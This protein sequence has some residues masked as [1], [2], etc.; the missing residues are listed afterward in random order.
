MLAILLITIVVYLPG[1]HGPFLLDDI[2][3][4]EPI[5]RWMAGDLGWMSAVLDNRSG[6]TGRPI[7]ML[8]F[9]LDVRRTGSLDPFTFKPTNLAIHLVCGLAA[10]VL[11]RQVLQAAQWPESALRWV[12][13]AVMA[14][15][16]WM[17]VQLSTVL[18]I[19]QRMAQLS[20]LWMLAT[21]VI[22]LEARRR[23]AIRVSIGR[24]ALL[25]LAVPMAALLAVFSKENGAL[26][27]PLAA[28]AEY[29]LF[30]QTNRPRAVLPF[31]AATVLLPGLLVL[32]YI[33][34]NP[35]FL[36][37]GY[38]SRDFTL[39]ERLLTEPRILWDYLQTA[40]LP[41]GERLGIYHDN[42]KVST[43]LFTPWTT[44]V[45]IGAWLAVIASA[46][47]FRRKAPVFTF[48]V[49]GF[50]VAHLMESGPVALE[51]YFEHRNYLPS[52][53]A[54]IAV[55]GAIYPLLFGTSRT[56]YFHRTGIALMVSVALVYAMGTL[57]QALAWSTERSFLALQYSYNPDSP[58]L[59]SVLAASAI[60]AGDLPTALHFID[61]G[62]RY[63]EDS[64]RGTS[65]LWRFMAYCES[66][67]KPPESL[68]GELESRNHGR[69][70]NYGMTA[71]DL[72]SAK[73]E[74]SC[75][76]LDAPRLARDGLA[77]VDRSGLPPTQQQSWRTRYNIGRI[78]AFSGD[79]RGAEVIVH[80]AWLD[81]DRNN[82]I[83]VLLFQLNASLGDVDACSIVLKSLERSE[84]GDDYA[85]TR[86]IRSFRSALPSIEAE[87]RH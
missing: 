64:E 31:F 20:A 84:G 52:T 71:W 48:G 32:G 16:L 40:F 17:P 12:P 4:L 82:G 74:H 33:A 2:G 42:V 34:Y 87:H 22:Y 72:L 65:T 70:T 57:N 81:S 59:L 83:G 30:S 10:C 60:Q 8:S 25:W 45:A 11:T 62:E 53:F 39:S 61:E 27:L 69:I 77:W 85:L 78:V 38:A 9:L 66:Q 15:W 67:T 56:I 73:V 37:G 29:T 55:I 14:I 26:A 80:K 5:T 3:N 43:G 63:S 75:Q 76:G 18:Y 19:V 46:I 41:T 35:H 47:V 44:I 6:P 7:S 68:Y 24:L 49:F 79:L 86:V 23:L 36:S 50:L 58:R 1:L 21:L 28:V 54:I 13:L 51:L